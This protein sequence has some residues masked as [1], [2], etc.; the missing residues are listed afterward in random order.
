MNW[1]ARYL[2]LPRSELHCWGLVCRV[3]QA[4]LGIGLP[5]YDGSGASEEERAEV[6]ALVRHEETGGVWEPIAGASEVRPFDV[7]VFRRG[8]SRSHIGLAVDPR[9]ML[10]MDGQAQIARLTDPSWKHRLKGVY[11]HVECAGAD[12]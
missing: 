11:R 8:R 4:E 12:R 9:H 6:E 2:G 5:H 10:H 7:L 1:S 3:Y